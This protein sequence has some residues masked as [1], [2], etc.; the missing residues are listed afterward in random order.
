MEE[1][2]MGSTLNGKELKARTHENMME[3]I[4]A[5]HAK[6]YI[7]T[8]GELHDLIHMLMGEEEAEDRIYINGNHGIVEIENV[9]TNETMTFPELT[10]KS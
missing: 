6:Q 2:N 9:V 7:I 5:K 4:K 10:I 3:D 1:Y 8:E